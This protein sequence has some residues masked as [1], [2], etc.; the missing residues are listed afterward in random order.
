MQELYE[1]RRVT[2]SVLECKFLLGVLE[3]DLETTNQVIALYTVRLRREKDGQ[4]RGEIEAQRVIQERRRIVL[5]GFIRRFKGMLAERKVR[6]RDMD[7]MFCRMLVLD[8]T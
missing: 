6:L 7:A 4:A 1:Q 8:S 5:K 3:Q 2:I